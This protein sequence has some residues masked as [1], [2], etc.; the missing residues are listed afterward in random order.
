M[1]SRTRRTLIIVEDNDP[2]AA[3]LEVALEG[4]SGVELVRFRRA[5]DA[6]ARFEQDGDIRCC[7][8]VTD[9]QLPQMDGLEL[10]HLVRERRPADAFP[11]LVTSGDS[12]PKTPE[13]AMRLGA[14]AYFR[15]PYSPSEVRRTLE[16][17]LD[18][19]NNRDRAV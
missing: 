14:N 1:K 5:E 15:K 3:T 2:C 10:V 16:Q 7:A 4:L 18:E 17:L 8:L 19:E 12:D 11:I 6:L 9:L 13:R